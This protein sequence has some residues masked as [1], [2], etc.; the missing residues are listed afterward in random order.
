MKKKIDR[1]KL[2]F[3]LIALAPAFV[4]Y[5]LFTLWPN[6][7]SVYYSLLDWNGISEAKFVGLKNFADLLSDRYLW[8]GLSVSLTICAVTV[9]LTMLIGLVL[10]YAL[11]NTRSKLGTF[12]Q[13]LFYFPN[14]I[15]IVVIALLWSFIFDGDMGLLNALL[16]IFT[17]KFEGK[18]WLAYKSTALLCVMA[19]IIWCNVGFHMI[20]Y[21]NAMKSI[22]PSMYEA[23]TLAGASPWQKLRY[24]TLPLI[25][26]TL[27]TSATFLI[28]NA[29][30]T[31]E[32]ILLMTN[33]GP[34]GSTSSLAMYM[35]VQAFGNVG[36]GGYS[37]RR[38][39]YAA[40]VGMVLMLVT[41]AVK[42]VMD[43]C[44]KREDVQY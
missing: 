14:I 19:P 23:A 40:A 10:A 38:Y 3:L 24:V 36:V 35:Y 6:I 8:T 11:T 17:S 41:L 28:L 32:I 4:F 5:V 25:Q 21:I 37:V 31:F 29:F 26:T 42:F 44:V 15:P 27:L 22:P 2:G 39:G 30:R 20:I 43:R 13:T 33:G 16:G 12:L 18:Y 7:L 9:P 34:N 1:R